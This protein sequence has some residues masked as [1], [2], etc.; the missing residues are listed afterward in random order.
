MDW[1]I[2]KAGKYAAKEAIAIAFAGACLL[3]RYFPI[4]PDGNYKAE[5]VLYL[6]IFALIYFLWDYV[7]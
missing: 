3:A 6:I 1:W 5:A 4:F 7:R 2:R